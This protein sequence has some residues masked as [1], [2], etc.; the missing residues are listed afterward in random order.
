VPQ[1]LRLQAQKASGRPALH[2]PGHGWPSWRSP[3]RTPC[4]GSA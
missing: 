4:T 2:R 3:R 1:W